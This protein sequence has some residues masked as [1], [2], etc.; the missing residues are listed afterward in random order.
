MAAAL[1]SNRRFLILVFALAL[2]PRLA[3]VVLTRDLPIGLDDMF[4]Y[5]MLARSIVAGDGYRWYGEDDLK[6][7][8]RYLPMEIPE[9]YDPR[10][11]Q[12]SFRGPGYPAF[13]AVAY[14]VVGVG[15]AR[16]FGARIIQAFLIALL[17]PLTWLLATKVGIKKRGAQLSAIIIAIIPLLIVY[18]LALA[19]E[20][21]FILLLTISLILCLTYMDRD[22]KFGF[23]ITGF[24]LGLTAL[25]RSVVTGFLPLILL[26]GLW[27]GWE[28]R[29]RLRNSLFLV[30][31]FFLITIPWMV[32]NSLLHEQPTWLE[33]S[34][35]YNMYM[36]YHPE[37]TGKFEF[38]ISLDLLPILDDAERHQQGMEAFEKFVQEDP[39][40]V[41]YLVVRKM[42]FQ[43]GLDKRAL[44]YFYSNGI[45][46]SLPTPVLG[47]AF[48]LAV[49]PFVIIGIGAAIG[50]AFGPFDQRTSLL[51]IFL[52]YY[53]L[54]HSLILGDARFHV[55]LFPIFTILTA[56]AFTERPWGGA[57]RWRFVLAFLL[58][59]LLILNWA[60]ELYL[61][62]D[63]LSAVF[64]PDGHRLRLSY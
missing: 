6:L 55:P 2:I 9:E 41:P 32:R 10:G 30:F 57:P 23:F 25:T 47:A 27:W 5:D 24:I 7:I 37:S 33:T 46:G 48:F 59:S 22:S 44:I 39:W 54:A 17:A 45:L 14:R 31:G 42:G 38:G 49:I 53:T 43:F 12:T 34:L 36:G 18:P 56:Y 50:L 61:D 16:L 13:L 20:N 63:M 15:E 11:I 8:Q 3:L 35:G 21:L 40:R 26:W 64:G 58:V 60:T 4:Q 29:Y 52:L 62:W 51:I 19:S 1:S 28:K